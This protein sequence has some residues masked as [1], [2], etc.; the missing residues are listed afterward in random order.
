MA[1][2]W[3]TSVSILVAGG[4]VAGAVYL[5]LRPSAA[6]EPTAATT[7][8]AAQPVDP[9]ATSPMAERDR[10]RGWDDQPTTDL[11][12]APPGRSRGEKE[13]KVGS[14]AEQ[15]MA[16]APPLVGVPSTPQE[17]AERLQQDAGKAFEG[18]RERVRSDCWDT[19]PDDPEAP[20][21]VTMMLSLSYGADGRVIASG[22][23]EPREG[24]REGNR[25]GS[26][27][28]AARSS[29]LAA[30]LDPLIHGLDV[31][32]PGSNLAVELHVTIP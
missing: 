19:L 1:L 13:K 3:H 25:A 10:Q 12:P 11:A 14:E 5:A 31:P 27:R 23:T 30:C 18:I 28:A 2:P 17:V 9:F 32:A 6:P 16:V 20:D 24:N 21:E 8:R 26:P 15:A 22:I 29:A 7:K 4:L